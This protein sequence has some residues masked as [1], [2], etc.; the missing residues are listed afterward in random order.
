MCIEINEYKDSLDDDFS[1]Y[2]NLKDIDKD[3]EI[4]LNK[5]Y[6]NSTYQLEKSRGKAT[7]IIEIAKIMGFKIYTGKFKERNLS[8]TIGISEKLRN[9]YGSNKVIILNNQDTD[10]HILFTLAHEIAH[11]IFDYKRESVGYSNT[12]RTNEAQTDIE[13]RANRFAASFL[14]PQTVFIKKY[15]EN[16]CIEDLSNY[17][18]V[19]ETAVKMRIQELEL[20]NGY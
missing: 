5:F 8:G 19:P 13:V 7:P 15:K 9:Q 1:Q 4:L 17:F 10:K 11:Y 6:D 20:G 2:F 12:Y 18:N 14:M 16:L 3:A